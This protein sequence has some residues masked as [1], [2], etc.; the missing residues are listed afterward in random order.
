MIVDCILVEGLLGT[1]I[2][3]LCIGGRNIRNEIDLD[4]AYIL[5]EINCYTELGYIH[6][7]ALPNRQ[8]SCLF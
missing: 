3:V 2:N 1:I 5:K 6:N 7:H 4:K 8:E